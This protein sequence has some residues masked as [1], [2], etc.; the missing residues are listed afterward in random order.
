MATRML[1]PDDAQAIRRRAAALVRRGWTQG[2][3]ATDAGGHYQDWESS[4]ACRFCAEGALRR[5][6]LEAGAPTLDTAINR[7]LALTLVCAR[8]VGTRSLS[9]WN[10]TPGRTADEVAAALEGREGRA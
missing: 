1:T 9:A 6:A 5:A 2:V 3:Y 7:A 8:E 10:D 4:R